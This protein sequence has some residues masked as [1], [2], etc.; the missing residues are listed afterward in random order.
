MGQHLPSK[1]KVISRRM[2]KGVPEDFLLSKFH[3]E[4]NDKE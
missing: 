3:R 1:K 4:I 2:G